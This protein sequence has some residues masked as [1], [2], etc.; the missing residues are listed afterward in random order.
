MSTSDTLMIFMLKARRPEKYKERRASELSGPGGRPIQQSWDFSRLS[1]EEFEVY[2]ALA[3]KV[4][5]PSDGVLE[6]GV[7]HPG[8]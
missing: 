5:V 6:I 4:Q 2:A 1:N 3:A 7:D 8:T